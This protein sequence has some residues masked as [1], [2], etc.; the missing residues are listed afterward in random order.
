MIWRSPDRLD[1]QVADLWATAAGSS[2][3][4]LPLGRAMIPA[5]PPCPAR[6]LIG[7]PCAT[8]GATRAAQ[9]LLGGRLP[10][11]VAHNPLVTLS[12]LIFVTAGL[13]APLWVRLGGRVP[14]IRASAG[15]RV[16]LAGALAANWA[17][18]ILRAAGP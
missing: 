2:I 3:A 5:L 11:A 10:E 18:V 6:A 13:A 4:L 9:A 7:L 15:M 1:R 17:Y 12:A 14:E 8:C 16:A